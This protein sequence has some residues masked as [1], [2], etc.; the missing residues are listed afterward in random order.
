MI[1]LYQHKTEYNKTKFMF[2][3]YTFGIYQ[4]SKQS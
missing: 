2:S 1:L 4:V 3:E